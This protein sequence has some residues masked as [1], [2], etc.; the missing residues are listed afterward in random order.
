ML[1]YLVRHGK[2]DLNEAGRVQGLIDEPLSPGGIDQ[3]QKLAQHLKLV[4]FTEAWSSPLKRAQET[5][6]TILAAQPRSKAKL[7]VDG[8]LRARSMGSA[9]GQIWAQICEALNECGIESED[10]LKRRLHD[11]L[12]VLIKMHIP[13]SSATAT[14]TATATTPLSPLSP[15]SAANPFNSET[16]A[17]RVRALPRPGIA[18]TPSACANSGKSG[19]GIVLVL[20][21]QECLTALLKLL[22][23]SEA[24]SKPDQTGDK[25]DEMPKSPIDL[26]IPDSVVV[27]NGDMVGTGMGNASVAILRVWWEEGEDGTLEARGR[28]EAWGDKEHLLDEYED[29]HDYV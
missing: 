19:S 29:V 13:A 10:Q 18:R 20:S 6:R 16:V 11:W 24:V 23:G 26:H 22:T 4:P 3:A 12:S 1:L 28:L 15:L 17:S 8:R 21:H 5:A 27:R 9:E 2:T 14:A 7:Y 25:S